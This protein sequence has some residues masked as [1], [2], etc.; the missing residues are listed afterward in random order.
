VLATHTEFE[1]KDFYLSHNTEILFECCQLAFEQTLVKYREGA[2]GKPI[3]NI[4]IQFDEPKLKTD[5]KVY[6]ESYRFKLIK[7]IKLHFR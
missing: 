5:L 2:K 6:L 4:L 1:L 7:Y 3:E